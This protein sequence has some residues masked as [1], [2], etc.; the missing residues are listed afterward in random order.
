MAKRGKKL[1]PMQEAYKKEQNRIKNFIRRAEKRGY[2]FEEGLIP[3]MP[4]RV[5]QKAL[6]D[7]KRINQYKLYKHSEFYRNESD[8]HEPGRA[9]RQFEREISAQAGAHTRQVNK[10]M[11]EHGLDRDEANK[12]Y[13]KQRK[14]KRQRE[15]N[16][17][18]REH[19]YD[20]W[21]DLQ[22]A[23][24]KYEHDR[25]LQELQEEIDEYTQQNVQEVPVT[26][27]VPHI[28]P[29][30]LFETKQEKLERLK[31]ELE[32]VQK[33]IEEEKE[34]ST[35]TE[36]E[37]ENTPSD[38]F[39]EV[40]KKINEQGKGARER[41]YDNNKDR[42]PNDTNTPPERTT[43]V[44]NTIEDMINSW[45]P[46]PRWSEYWTGVKEDDKNRLDRMLQN[47]IENEGRTTVAERLE[48]QAEYAISLADAICY[49]SG[50]KGNGRDDVNR[51]F[52][53]FSAII[54][55]RNLTFEENAKW[56]TYSEEGGI[57]N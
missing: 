42:I 25:E 8:I 13:W 49:G 40:M 39:K 14:E 24:R 6:E 26:V 4:K 30:P 34:Q 52:T 54:M 46:D 56:T 36:E 57:Y 32:E 48:R 33:E 15:N 47:A 5:T 12:I 21:E 55:G 43:L 31:K 50:S 53:E 1:T 2:H 20:S 51:A 10:L 11:R 19:G 9:R 18:A 38:F 45:E 35:Y 7:I 44:L 41:Y 27:E 23:N 37:I 29:A 28:K 3:E 17:Y 22:E 16:Q